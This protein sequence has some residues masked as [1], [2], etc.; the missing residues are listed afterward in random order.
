M[1][2]YCAGGNYLL[3]LIGNYIKRSWFINY[4][5][6]LDCVKNEYNTVQYTFSLIIVLYFFFRSKYIQKYYVIQI[7]SFKLFLLLLNSYMVNYL[8]TFDDSIS[9]N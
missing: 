5:C 2:D 8:N 1:E 7:Y 3:K 4:I 9:I 6:S